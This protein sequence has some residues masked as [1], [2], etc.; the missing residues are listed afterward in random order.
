[1]ENRSFDCFSSCFQ[2][3]SMVDNYHQKRWFCRFFAF[4]AQNVSKHMQNAVFSP[5]PIW[6]TIANI[7]AKTVKIVKQ[8]AKKAK[9]NELYDICVS[10]GGFQCIYQNKN[11]SPKS[12]FLIIFCLLGIKYV[13]TH[14]NYSNLNEKLN[15]IHW[16]NFPKTWGKIKFYEQK[17]CFGAFFAFRAEN[18]FKHTQNEVLSPKLK[19]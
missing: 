2:T 8:T 18:A 4:T 15:S 6:L 17:R 16:L 9:D 3:L 5:K 12:L 7:T 10:W 19:V 1:M 14:A 13:K 11:F